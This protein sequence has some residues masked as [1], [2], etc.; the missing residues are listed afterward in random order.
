MLV[1]SAASFTAL[2]GLAFAVAV[3]TLP[4]LL[5]SCA[6]AGVL[7]SLSISHGGELLVQQRLLAATRQVQ[8]GLERARH[9]AQ[10]QGHPCALALG[11]SGWQ[12][13][14]AAELPA[15]TAALGP[16]LSG[17]SSGQ[18]Q[19]QHNLHQLRFTANGLVLGGGTIWLHLAGTSQVRC[20]VISLP[21]GISR[22]GVQRR[23]RCFP[24]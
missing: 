4:E 1:S 18:L 19:L 6:I 11:E 2:K 3:M 7:A 21:L 9:Q 12:E 23:G 14:E 10:R 22:H 5:T 17:F 20:V 15:C 8:Q 13:P 24:A 16:L